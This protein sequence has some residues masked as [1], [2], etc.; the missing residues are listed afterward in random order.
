MSLLSDEERAGVLRATRVRRFGR[1]EV[2]F[3]EGD[4]GDTLHIVERG[5]FAARS[6]ST[7]GHVLT[8]NVFRPGAVFGELALLSHDGQRTATVVSLKAGA[9][10]VLRRQDFEALR[11]TNPAVDRFLLTIMAERNRTLTAQ[12]IELM[13]TPAP[14]RVV[15]EL[16]R[17]DELGIA[18]DDDGWI[19]L[20]QDELAMLTGSTRATVN[21]VLRQAETAGMIELARGRSR[22]VQRAA[23]AKLAR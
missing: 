4:P 22:V 21:R 5:L 20:S 18:S 17:L 3:H 7:L 9:T 11:G 13:F 23:M 19:Q 16:L 2:V 10:R 1:N 6:S 8:V 14:K 12:L 15:R